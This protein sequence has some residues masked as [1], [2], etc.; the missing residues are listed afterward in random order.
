MKKRKKATQRRKG[1]LRT[2]AN[3]LPFLPPSLPRP[4]AA[5][6]KP[7][8]KTD[9]PRQKSGSSSPAAAASLPVL[10]QAPQSS[11][12]TPLIA[13]PGLARLI[14]ATS[15]TSTLPDRPPSLPPSLHFSPVIDLPLQGVIP[16][17]IMRPSIEHATGTECR[18]NAKSPSRSK[19]RAVDSSASRPSFA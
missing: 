8:E 4:P 18:T 6:S 13:V 19:C 11:S 9:R 2:R 14:P 16:R 10:I 1:G 5:V 7:T 15:A 3:S 17:N 12:S